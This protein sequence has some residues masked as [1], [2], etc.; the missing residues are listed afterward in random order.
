MKKGLPQ[1]FWLSLGCFLELG[2]LSYLIWK[3]TFRAIYW[4]KNQDLCPTDRYFMIIFWRPAGVCK[5]PTLFCLSLC[6]LLPH[7]RLPYIR[8]KGTSI[9]LIW[10]I[11]ACPVPRI[12]RDMVLVKDSVNPPSYCTDHD[13]SLE[14]LHKNMGVL[15][16]RTFRNAIFILSDK[17]QGDGSGC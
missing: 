13:L 4:Y 7:I 2:K 5:Q 17:I 15:K 16:T 3:R 10:G 9:A 14:P 1:P 6:N 8:W 11:V 12:C